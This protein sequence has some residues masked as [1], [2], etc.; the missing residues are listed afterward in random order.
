MNCQEC[1]LLLLDFHFETLEP[2]RHAEVAAHLLQCQSCRATRDKLGASVPDQLDWPDEEP[3]AGLAARTIA[4]ASA[5]ETGFAREDEDDSE[6]T[7]VPA[8]IPI[9][10]PSPLRT[11]IKAF[12]AAAMLAV[13]AWSFLVHQR[14]VSLVAAMDGQDRFAP[15]GLVSL[16]MSVFDAGSS[17]PI[18][19]ARMRVL[20][21]SSDGK[22]TVIYDGPSDR[23]G[24]ARAG[25]RLPELPEG[26]YTLELHAERGHES[27]KLSQP[28]TV[29]RRYRVLLSTDKPSYQP[30][31]TIHVRALAREA[32]TQKTPEGREL[33]FS[34]LDPRGNK[35]GKKRVP[36][37]AYGTASF[38]FPLAD[39]I[40]L[41]AWKVEAE[42]AGAKSA[43]DVSV[44]RYSLPK[45]AVKIT[46]DKPWYRPGQVVTGR[47]ESRYFFGKP[48]AGAKAKITAGVF[49]DR[50][51]AVGEA[52]GTA[53]ADGVYGFEIP[54]PHA[55]PGIALMNGSAAVDVEV[56]ITDSAGQQVVKH[57]ALTVA[58]QELSVTLVP[59]GGVLVP[60]V[61]NRLL[62]LVVR[63]DGEPIEGA[64]VTLVSDLKN[65]ASAETAGDGIAVLTWEPGSARRDVEFE[66]RTRDGQ[67]VRQRADLEARA[68]PAVIRTERSLYTAGETVK[69]EVL[70]ASPTG[71]IYLDVVRD[72]QTIVT[73][74]VPLEGRRGSFSIDLPA[75]A[76]GTVSLYAYTPG[77]DTLRARRTLF[78]GE[79]RSL[80]VTFSGDRET[81]RPGEPATLEL[82]VKGEDGKPAASSV[83]VAVVDESVFALAAKEPALLKAYFLLAEELSKPRYELDP[84]RV[85]GDRRDR[86]ASLL[87]SHPREDEVTRLGV[88]GAEELRRRRADLKKEQ[89]RTASMSWGMGLLLLGVLFE[90]AIRFM[91]EKIFAGFFKDK[92][93]RTFALL[94]GGGL[95]IVMKLDGSPE[96]VAVM[97][98]LAPLAL[99]LGLE[100]F[101]RLFTGEFANAA[102]L[103]GVLVISF[104]GFVSIFGQNIR[105]LFAVSASALSGDADHS[106]TRG[107]SRFREKK[108]LGNFGT[109]PG[110]GFEADAS[111]APAAFFDVAEPVPEPQF[112]AKQEAEPEGKAG[113]KPKDVAARSPDKSK[114]R[115]RSWF[116]ETMFWAP[117]VITGADG[118]AS[119]T[120][121]VADSITSWRISATASGADGRLGVGQGAL[122]VFQ[123][124]FVDID[125]PPALTVGDEV[126]IPIAVHNYLETEQTVLLDVDSAAWFEPLSPLK[127]EVVLA[128][129]EVK[130][131]PLKLRAKE[132][133]ARQQLT[134]YAFGN[135]Q[136]DAQG[137]VARL[138]DAI[139]REVEVRPNGVRNEAVVSGTVSGTVRATAKAPA[140]SIPGTE[141]LLLRLYPGVFAAAL[142][143]IEGMFRMP[144]GCF[145]QTSSATYPNVLVLDYLRRTNRS[146]PELELKA[147]EY[148]QQGYQRLLAFEVQ[149]GG[150]EWFGRAPANQVL[151]AYGLLEFADMARVY[152]VDPAIIRRT[153][154]WLVSK[155]GPDGA[156]QADRQNLA[157]GLYRDQFS[158][159]I[160][161]TAYI[162]WALV[163]SG[164]RGAATDSALSWLRS[165]AAELND[166]YTVALVANALLA[167]G[168]V[169]VAEPLI[170]KLS[171]GSRAE[172]DRRFVPAGGRTAVFSGGRA[173]DVETTALA[174]LAFSR[175]GRTAEVAGLQEWLLAARDPHG[176]WGS[177]QATV[178][179]MRSLL[180][181]GSSPEASGTVAVRVGGE[182]LATQEFTPDNSEVVR[183]VDLSRF[184]NGSKPV[185]VELEATGSVRPQFQLVTLAWV[186]KPRPEEALTLSV[187]FDR[188]TLALDDSLTTRVRATWKRDGPSG[189][190]MLA[191]AVPPGFEVDAGSVGRL[192][193]EGKVARFTVTGKE[194]L[195]YVDRLPPKE[196]VELS[197]KLLARFPVKA[198]APS[199]VAYL[200]YQP[201][202]RAESSS[203]E[204]VV[205]R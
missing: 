84:A 12:A 151:T 187:D 26:G 189:M 137:K 140:S 76:A 178:L 128:P 65:R 6:A 184:A 41:G 190:V 63:P 111:P 173:A 129:G 93:W 147:T 102:V 54:L 198:T 87:F 25:L 177:T 108:T 68:L 9:R 164:Y 67:R 50:F 154:E 144:S 20:L 148:I 121:P 89:S 83:G 126:E 90:S 153:Q 197:Y 75:E 166:L 167:N 27:T 132:F 142:D 169:S 70:A 160:G 183:T 119:L 141:K 146:K 138:Q 18:D 24:T 165:R 66:V 36:V 168:N 96:I 94:L 29:E 30:G 118:L 11:G 91:F 62:A 79:P 109:A 191:L 106:R 125:L 74:T 86:A 22:E 156:W 53:D 150:Y 88:T 4:A 202:I 181:A 123:D 158:G 77:K 60:G 69:G 149:G 203:A 179:A 37:D 161:A 64:T 48:A 193:A 44:A 49:V 176:S 152:E 195:L 186:P 13:G 1:S 205:R 117:S 42:L 8:P 182:T 28:V 39:E 170:E 188:V 59:D 192:V 46:T 97:V 143:G 180:A 34:V 7:P 185:E 116:P 85:V 200:Y 114:V 145:E 112:E 115:V 17:K 92:W 134:V 172:G 194:L 45:F 157:D 57:H 78:V 23:H 98:G 19:G 16:R 139:R 199:S 10:R 51:R 32:A 72:G 171:A 113:R 82:Q 99:V 35:V 120:I 136:K 55:L 15:G 104:F 105:A 33:V 100:G 133:G 155:Q 196:T 124:F 159:A 135:E 175:A 14:E 130:G 81:Y 2:D 56:A 58:E 40:L 101:V 131:V 31:Q 21:R 174:M 201:E 5:G 110:G 61:E 122:R 3:P 204:L 80:Q 163:E 73:E 47:I 52:T 71:A 162:T 95:G 107:K 38:D 127:Q 43:I 103:L